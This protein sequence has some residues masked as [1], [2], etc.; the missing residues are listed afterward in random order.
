M[1][2]CLCLLLWREVIAMYGWDVA[3]RRAGL[4]DAR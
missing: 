1:V 2:L 4:R 3:K